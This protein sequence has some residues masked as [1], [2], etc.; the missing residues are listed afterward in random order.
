[1]RHRSEREIWEEEERATPDCDFTFLSLLV[2]CIQFIMSV[3]LI[4]SDNEDF[5]VDKEVAERSV[6]IKNMLEG[7]DGLGIFTM[8]TCGVT[9][10]SVCPQMSVIATRLSLFPTS[11]P[12]SFAKYV[13]LKEIFANLRWRCSNSG[14]S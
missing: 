10:A 8:L 9:K 3:K 1:M 6:L 2:S 7:E 14:I 4:S 11:P 13:C 12:R 5:T